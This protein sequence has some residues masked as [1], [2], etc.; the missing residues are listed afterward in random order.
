MHSFIRCVFYQSFLPFY[1]LFFSFSWQ[2]F[3]FLFDFNEP[4]HIHSFLH[5][6]CFG[7]IS[8]KPLPYRSYRFSPMLS[9]RSFIILH[10]TFRSWS[11]LNYF[12]QDIW[13]VSRFI[14]LD[15]DVHFWNLLKKL[16]LLYCYLCFVKDQL[17]TFMGVYFGDLYSFLW[18][19][20]LFFAFHCPF[21]DLYFVPDVNF[22]KFSVPFISNISSVSFLLFLLVF[23]LC[24]CHIYFKLF[25]SPWLFCSG[26]FQS[27]FSLIFGF[28]G[29][30]W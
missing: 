17:I 8:K 3:L 2:Y 13:S 18:T 7:V 21:L 23:P 11:I 9:F 19:I 10:F 25:Q 27:F 14:S 1:D 16:P 26:F 22:W 24:V 5:K 30:Y 28:Q 6:L 20:C 15:V 12:V 4:Q 29:F